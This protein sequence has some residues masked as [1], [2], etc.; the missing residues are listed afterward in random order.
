MEYS[1]DMGETWNV[2]FAETPAANNTLCTLSW[3]APEDGYIYLRFSG[4]YNY[5]DNICGF[6][7]P[8]LA[9]DETHTENEV[10]AGYYGV[11]NVNRTLKANV[12]NTFCVPFDMTAEEIAANLGD[13]AEVKELTGITA[14]ENSVEMTFGDAT[15]IL[16]GKAYMVKV[17]EPVSKITVMKKTVTTDLIPSEA[18]DGDY[19]LTFHG[20][21]TSMNAPMNSYIISSN[22]F[23]EVDSD[24]VTLKAF[25]GYIT[26]QNNG[27]NAVKGMLLYF[28]FDDVPTAIHATEQNNSLQIY[29]LSG[30]RVQN[31]GHGLYIVNGKKVIK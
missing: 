1:Y 9:L 24:D 14:S 7:L 8:T 27:G 23:Y 20:N 3:T 12:W 16:A 6:K 19:T 30:R 26:L 21:Y 28:G 13:G 5:I 17:S 11:V 29:D 4:R 25:R 22:V 10:V 18:T 15:S 2:A 31:M